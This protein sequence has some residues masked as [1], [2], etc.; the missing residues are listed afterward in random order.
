MSDP[1]KVLG[2]SPDASDEEVKKAYF[3]LARKY[4]PDKYTDSELAEL[5]AEKMKEVNAAYDAIQQMRANGG[6]SRSGASYSYGQSNGYSTGNESG[7]YAYVRRLIN[8]GDIINAERMLN[9]VDPAKR[10]AEWNFLMGCVQIRYHRYADATRYF[11]AACREDPYNTE[12]RMAQDSL[13]RQ[14]EDYGGGYRTVTRPGCGC[15]LCDTCCTLLC[16]NC[17][18][19]CCCDSHCDPI[20]GC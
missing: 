10:N 17:L 19:D 16:A 5:A 12:Y 2:V 9:Q 1:Y 20:P 4:H 8:A 14:S 3:A 11:D 6:A 15:G 7:D 13:R 18:C